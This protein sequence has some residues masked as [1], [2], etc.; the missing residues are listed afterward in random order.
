[1]CVS[2]EATLPL[3]AT[4][5]LLFASPAARL[6]SGLIFWGGHLSAF[7]SPHQPPVVTIHGAD[8]E[9]LKT[10]FSLWDGTQ[11]HKTFRTGWFILGSSLNTPGSVHDLA[12]TQLWLT[13]GVWFF[14]S[15]RTPT[16]VC[17]DVFCLVR[18]NCPQSTPWCSFT[19]LWNREVK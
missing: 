12:S 16:R 13:P 14:C 10:V 3:A 19:S 6:S 4:A 1:M 11:S 8:L 15:W 9:E 7:S 18:S 17:C 5:C 2:P